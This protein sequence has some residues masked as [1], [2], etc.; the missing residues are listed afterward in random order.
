MSSKLE[1]WY[2]QNVPSTFPSLT[3]NMPKMVHCG[4]SGKYILNV[5]FGNIFGIPSKYILN[6]PGLVHCE[7]VTWDIVKNIVNIPCRNTIV[8]FCG[9]F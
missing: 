5:L 4:E 8:T 2:I 9:K 7:H 1:I 3:K 6:L